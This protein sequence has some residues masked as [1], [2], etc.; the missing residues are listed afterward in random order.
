MSN[1]AK[2][3]K[4]DKEELQKIVQESFSYREVARKIG[5]V[6]TSGSANQSVKTMI[7]YYNF[8]ISHFTGQGWNNKSHDEL[9]FV[10]GNSYKGGKF[11]KRLIELRGQKCEHCGITEWLG[12][13]INLEVHHIDGDRTNNTFENLILLCP[14]CHSYTENYRARNSNNRKEISDEE[15]VQAL[16]DN[17]NIHS[18]LKQLNLAP[19]GGNYNR[20]YKL[21][22]EFNIEHLK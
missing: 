18:A 3:K 4:M 9:R 8:D 2:W 11:T 12:Q 21:I 10:K 13:P 20:A 22:E 16:K 14:N 7:E 6:P 5:Y 1:I 15:F 17:I 19:K